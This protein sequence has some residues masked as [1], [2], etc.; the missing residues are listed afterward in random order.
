M[1]SIELYYFSGTGNSLFV[2]QELARSIPDSNLIPIPAILNHV[3]ESEEKDE[4]R[5]KILKISSNSVGFIFPCHGLS[6]PVVVKE[7]IEML[8]LKE[9]KYLFAITTRGGSAFHGFRIINKILAKEEKELDASFVIDMAMNDPKLKAFYVP[10]EKELSEIK[11][12]V[13][14]K[15]SFIE[16]NVIQEKSHHDDTKG[17]SFTR[18]KWL[19]F[20]LERL[21]IFLMNRFATGLKKYF[22]A[23]SKCTGCGIC[24]KMCLSNKIKM[25]DNKPVWQQDVKCYLCYGCLNFCPNHAIQIY[26]S[27]YMKSYTPEKG[28]YPHPYASVEDM[29][30][31]KSL[32]NMETDS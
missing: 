11:K 23:D 7:F 19:N 5:K 3:N 20:I 32:G 10:D 17:V 26:S 4:E 29:V 28:R 30:D 8:D 25:E 12:Q 21:V 27:V 22:Y 1:I 13:K 31:Q 6:V 18:F 2:A 16:N 24:E 14:S 9:P 15:I